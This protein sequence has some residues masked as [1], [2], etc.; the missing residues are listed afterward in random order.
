M[1]QFLSIV[2]PLKL[3]MKQF[4]LVLFL[5]KDFVLQ[6]QI[7]SKGNV[8]RICDFGLM[9][10]LRGSAF[11]GLCGDLLFSLLFQGLISILFVRMLP[12]LPIGLL[13]QNCRC[14]DDAF[15]DH[16]VSNLLARPVLFCGRSELQR[17][18]SGLEFDRV[19]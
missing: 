18:T 7:Q 4:L 9:M 19:G 17:K 1:T 2:F 12:S 16:F 14:M 10:D 6:E 11:A 13:I 3:Q 8:A 15:L 5:L